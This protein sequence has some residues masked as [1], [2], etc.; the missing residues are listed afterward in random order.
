MQY[1]ESQYG[2]EP[3][4]FSHVDTLNGMISIENTVTRRPSIPGEI[5]KLISLRQI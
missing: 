4:Y 5:E 3:I 1:E 2:N